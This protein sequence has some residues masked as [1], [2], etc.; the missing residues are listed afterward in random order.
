MKITKFD[1]L[2][3]VHTHVSLGTENKEQKSIY[4]LSRMV[5]QHQY[6]I[7]LNFDIEIRERFTMYFTWRRGEAVPHGRGKWRHAP[8]DRGR[9]LHVQK[10]NNDIFSQINAK[11][12]VL[13][14]LVDGFTTIRERER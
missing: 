11:N 3:V 8:D 5:W 9:Y 2:I 4:F 14:V 13:L 7:E 10:T 12:K 6:K 1:R